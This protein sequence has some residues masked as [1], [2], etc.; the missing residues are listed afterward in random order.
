M[1]IVLQKVTR[2]HVS[3]ASTDFDEDNII[4]EIANGF[5]VLLGVTHEDTERDAD[6]LIEKLLKLRLFADADSNTFMERNIQE[7]GGGILVI[8]QFT[9]YGNCKKGTRPSFTDAARPEVAKPLYNYFIMKLRELTDL[10]VEG[11]EF[12]EHMEVSLTNDGPITLI[13]ES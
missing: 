11:G 6:V 2:A 13:L 7:E 12:G 8:S 5:V 9:L 1:K 4:G 10:R 3:V